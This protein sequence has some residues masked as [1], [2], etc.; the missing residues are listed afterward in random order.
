MKNRANRP[1][2]ASFFHVEEIPLL[3][4]EKIEIVRIQKER[5]VFLCGVRR[6]LQYSD[7]CMIFLL[8]RETVIIEGE[9]LTCVSFTGGA[10]GVRGHLL[11]L[12]FRK[13][14]HEE[15]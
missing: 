8:Q 1:S 10:V 15:E 11:S 4:R 3:E 6:I 2:A 7:R 5:R 9:G 12:R 13:E 14:V